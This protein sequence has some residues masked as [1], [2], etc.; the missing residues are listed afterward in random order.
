MINQINDLYQTVGNN[1]T[2]LTVVDLVLMFATAILSVLASVVAFFLGI[3][4]VGFQSI[5]YKDETNA[6]YLFLLAFVPFLYMSVGALMYNFVSILIHVVYIHSSTRIINLFDFDITKYNLTRFQNTVHNFGSYLLSLK[7]IVKNLILVVVTSVYL[8]I[9]LFYASVAVD[10]MI[11]KP[12]VTVFYNISVAVFVF[13]LGIL[14]AHMYDIMTTFTLF[15]NG[16][17]LHGT[18]SYSLS[19]LIQNQTIYFTRYY[20]AHLNN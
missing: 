10:I 12:N 19:Q 15:K 4:K 11:K 1:G 5:R 9:M 6:K 18:T 2:I 13:I 7:S 14:T 17:L 20:F 3:A 16:I 8:I